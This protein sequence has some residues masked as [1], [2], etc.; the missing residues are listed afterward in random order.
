MH[1]TEMLVTV[2]NYNSGLLTENKERKGVLIGLVGKEDTEVGFD[3]D[4][5]MKV[6]LG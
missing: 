3:K 5:D 6:G 4:R 2:T 1:I